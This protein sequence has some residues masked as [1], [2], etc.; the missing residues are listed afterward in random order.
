M[1]MIPVNYFYGFY[2]L[3]VVDLVVFCWSLIVLYLNRR[4]AKDHVTGSFFLAGASIII[5]ALV[6]IDSAMNIVWLF[7][8]LIASIFFFPARPYLVPGIVAAIVSVA[9]LISNGSSY[10]LLLLIAASAITLG[11]VNSFFRVNTAELQKIEQLAETDPLTGAGNRRAFENMLASLD[12]S[13]VPGRHVCLALY[14]LDDF[15]QLNDEFGHTTG[16]RVLERVVDNIMSM[17]RKAGIDIRVYRI[18]GDEFAVL[19]FTDIDRAQAICQDFVDYIE[20]YS[21]TRDALVTLSLGLCEVTSDHDLN[22]AYQLVD[23]ALYEA[24]TNGKSQLVVL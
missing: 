7:P 14:D 12:S 10:E 15:K 13:S 22:E 24:K 5:S 9:F 20:K 2:T 17:A 18:G 6:L 11:I 1:V 16:D 21:V 8:V 4:G 23:T 19:L 3:V